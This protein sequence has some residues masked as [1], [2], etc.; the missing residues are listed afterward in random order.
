VA[1][2]T[3]KHSYPHSWR[4]KKPVIFR[5]TVGIALVALVGQHPAAGEARRGFREGAVGVDGVGARGTLKHSYPHSW[6]SKKPVIFRN[7]PQW[8]IALDKP[9]LGQRGDHR[10]VGIA[11]VALVGQHPA[12]GEARRGFRE[13]PG[14]RRSRSS[15]A[16]RRNG[17]SPSTSRSRPCTARPC[18]RRHPLGRGDLAQRHAAQGLAVQGLDRLVEGDEP[19]RRVC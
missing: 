6:R 3:L 17:S 12:A 4:S 18:A 8:F 5:N 19:L 1:R 13:I 11:L 2:G 7:T 14:A 9:G 16:T 10:L 15:S